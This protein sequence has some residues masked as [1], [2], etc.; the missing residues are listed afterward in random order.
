MFRKN[1]PHFPATNNKYVGAKSIAHNAAL[2]RT[3]FRHH[4]DAH[5]QETT[6]SKPISYILA[7]FIKAY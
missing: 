3:R 4:F 6:N 1:I 7:N 2:Q 5:G